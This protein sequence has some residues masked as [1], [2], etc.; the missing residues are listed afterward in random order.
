MED[1]LPRIQAGLKNTG[2]LNGKSRIIASDIND[3]KYGY[4]IYDLNY[5]RTRGKI[6]EY[7]AQA[8]IIPCGRYGSW[9]YF[10]MEDSLL[11]GRRAARITLQ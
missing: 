10:S 8:Q 11:D 6:M 2:L 1:I 9:R 7:L 4:P 3:I 5:S